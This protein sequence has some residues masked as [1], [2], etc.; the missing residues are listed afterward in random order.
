MGSNFMTVEE[1]KSVCCACAAKIGNV[2]KECGCWLPIKVRMP[3]A[4]CPLNKWKDNN[5]EKISSS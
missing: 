2:C 5:D 4:E 3:S 1:R